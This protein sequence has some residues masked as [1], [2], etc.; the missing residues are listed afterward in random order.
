MSIRIS[1]SCRTPSPPC[2]AS[3]GETNSAGISMQQ[4]ECAIFFAAIA[5]VPQ[6]ESITFPLQF[7]RAFA[8]SST[9]FSSNTSVSLPIASASM[10]MHRFTSDMISLSVTLILLLDHRRILS[11]PPGLSAPGGMLLYVSAGFMPPGLWLPPA[12]YGQPPSVSLFVSRVYC[13]RKRA[14]K[15]RVTCSPAS[16][17]ASTAA[18]YTGGASCSTSFAPGADFSLIASKYSG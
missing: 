2:T 18:P 12:A 1:S 3:A 17:R 13:S 11:M 10:L 15:L 8:V 9:A 14:L 16:H 4:S 7:C 5:E 6:P